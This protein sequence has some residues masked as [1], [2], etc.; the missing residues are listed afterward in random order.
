MSADAI[1]NGIGKRLEEAGL[2]YFI[3]WE[4]RDLPAG[5]AKPYLVFEY[6]PVSRRDRSNAG[7]SVQTRGYVQVTV[8]SAKG[9]FATEGRQIAEAVAAVFDRSDPAKAILFED[10]MKIIMGDSAVL[11]G[12]PDDVSWRTPVRINFT[13]MKA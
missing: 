7:G 5:Q 8:V 9:E 12:Y 13:A 1:A 11:R 2:G 6:V 3:L 10:G 4:N